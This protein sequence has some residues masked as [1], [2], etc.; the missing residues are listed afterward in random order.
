MTETR[1]PLQNMFT[2]ADYFQPYYYFYVKTGEIPY[3]II[4]EGIEMAGVQDLL[5]ASFNS[6]QQ[7]LGTYL[8]PNENK[9]GM[10][11]TGTYWL[12]DGLLVSL[13]MNE[14]DH[15]ET[16]A[17]ILHTKEVEKEL[18]DKL[19]QLFRERQTYK[20]VDETNNLY[21]LKTF[22]YG[23]GFHKFK[24]NIPTIEL[25]DHYNDELV[26]L[27]NDIVERLNKKDEKGILLLHGK[28]GT[29]K[30]TYIRY[31]CS[32][33]NKKKLFIPVE[34]GKKIASPEF[35][36]LLDGYENSV[37]IIEDAESILKKRSNS[38][39]SA[40]A[41][42]LNL[43]DGLISDCYNIQVICTFN[44]NLGDIDD[45]LL[46]KGR[47]IAQYEFKELELDKTNALI[48]TLGH[49]FEAMEPM[50]LADI[51]H[52][53]DKNYHSPHKKIGFKQ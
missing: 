27:N 4:I 32:Q 22:Q 8:Y 51:Y 53:K 38:E 36:S 30:T 2:T 35:L 24:L 33:V 10:A 15:E 44:T 41:N 7:I 20:A 26:E 1:D 6:L 47:L 40:V 42:L 19:T 39:G 13:S 34:L 5:A 14:Y 25:N 52:L 9:E 21:L 16:T 28:P 49:G 12:G 23:M 31:L 29:G 45:A 50:T 46:R 17:I 18:L 11:P 3:R 48:K 37:L 43:S